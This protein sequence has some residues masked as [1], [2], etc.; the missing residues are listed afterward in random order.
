MTVDDAGVIYVS[1]SSTGAVYRVDAAY[2]PSLLHRF[3]PSEAFTPNGLVFHPSGY[4]LIAGGESLY[5]VPLED[6]AR[7]SRVTLPEPV[8][9]ADG[10]VWTADG[11]LAIVAYNANRVVALTSSNAWSSAELVGVAVYDEPASTVAVVLDPRIS[12][13]ETGW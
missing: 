7:A 4:L 8:S 3:E 12:P 11:R 10:V 2:E 6:P 1:D 13:A 9:G 5:K